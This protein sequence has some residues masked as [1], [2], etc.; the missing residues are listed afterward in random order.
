MDSHISHNSYLR[1]LDDETHELLELFLRAIL[2]LTVFLTYCHCAFTNFHPS[3]V[4]TQAIFCLHDAWRIVDSLS[5]FLS[6]A[7]FADLLF[8]IGLL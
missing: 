3:C 1:L 7:L 2:N 5:V 4:H 6:F 8:F